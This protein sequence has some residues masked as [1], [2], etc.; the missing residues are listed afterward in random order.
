MRIYKG[1]ILASDGEILA[2]PDYVVRKG[3]KIVAFFANHPGVSTL[4]KLEDA[5]VIVH[6]I[7][8]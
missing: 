7:V 1:M 4:Y 6:A 8:V 5:G 2:A 3:G